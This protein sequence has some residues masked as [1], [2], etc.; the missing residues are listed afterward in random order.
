[1]KVA[2]YF[3]HTEP[4][5]MVGKS[6]RELVRRGQMS[7]D[8]LVAELLPDENQREEFLRRSG[9]KMERDDGY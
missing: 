6:I 1:M 7:M 3:D 8:D 2:D 9:I 5:A 4:Q